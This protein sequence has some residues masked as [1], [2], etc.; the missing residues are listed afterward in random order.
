MLENVEA[1]AKDSEVWSLCLTRD[2]NG[3]VSGS[4]DHTVK[5]WNFELVD[6][7]EN[8]TK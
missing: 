4:A 2:K 5:F 3:F 8:K 7:E 1:H 6:D